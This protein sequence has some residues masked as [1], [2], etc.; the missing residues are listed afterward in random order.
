MTQVVLAHDDCYKRNSVGE[1]SKLITEKSLMHILFN[2]DS[3]VHGEELENKD[4]SMAGVITKFYNATATNIAVSGASNDLIYDSTRQYLQANPAPDLVVVGWTEHGREQWYFENEFHEINQLDVGKRIPEEFRQR[5]Q[6]WK[7]NMQKDGDWHRVMGHY[8]HNKIYNLHRWL[9]ERK[10]PHLFFA[11]FN[12]FFIPNQKEHL[13]WHDN[14]Y[15]PYNQNCCYGNWCREHGYNELTPGWHH[16]NEDA[17][18]AWANI[19]IEYM[20]THSIYDTIRQ[21]M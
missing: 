2:G 7:H 16:Y 1:L 5:Y 8:W 3:N 9:Y 4:L 20:H 21:R 11:T 10:I 14:F 13:D 19:L 15:N 17:H 18:A 6:F 12:S